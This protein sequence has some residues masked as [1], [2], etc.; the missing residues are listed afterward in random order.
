MKIVT[1]LLVLLALA[2]GVDRGAEYL[3]ERT[4]ADQAQDRLEL[5]GAVDVEVGGFP[6]LT[7]VVGKRFD[8][9]GMRA[10]HIPLGRVTA[11]Q[12]H[13]SARDVTVDY[14]NPAAARANQVRLQVLVP[15]DQLGRVAPE[16]VRVGPAGRHAVRVTAPLDLPGR[17]VSSRSTVRVVDGVV[18][19]RARKV[20]VGGTPLVDTG[21]AASM[22]GRLDFSVPMDSLP[23]GVRVTGVRAASGGVVVLGATG[24]VALARLGPLSG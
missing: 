19:V 1:V 9:V 10:G 21:L 12:L 22:R 4:V 7:Q 16:G 23:E 15:Y 2:L 6:F 11:R 5:A 17:E 8:E 20:T 3:A 18:L 24:D 13:V 14:S